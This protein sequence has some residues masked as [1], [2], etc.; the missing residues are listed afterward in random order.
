LLKK[1]SDRS[2]VVLDP[3]K[4][5]VNAMNGRIRGVLIST[6]AYQYNL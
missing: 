6:S 5:R 3:I 4:Q 1:L 2:A